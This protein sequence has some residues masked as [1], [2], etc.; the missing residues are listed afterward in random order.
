MFAIYMC[1]QRISYMPMVLLL[2]LWPP[3]RFYVSILGEW[4]ECAI[5][6]LLV[7]SA[8]THDSRSFL[9]PLPGLWRRELALSPTNIQTINLPA[10]SL[11]FW[12]E[13]ARICGMRPRTPHTRTINPITSKYPRPNGPDV[14]AQAMRADPKIQNFDIF[15]CFVCIPHLL[16]PACISGVSHGLILPRVNV[17]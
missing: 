14:V 7:A 5:L 12:A 17:L 3:Q 10:V 2:M 16:V 6:N 1:G 13:R 8:I 15:P 11:I 9:T 4:I